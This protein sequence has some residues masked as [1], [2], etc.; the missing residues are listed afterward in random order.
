MKKWWL[1][2][3]AAWLIWP[4]SLQ[5]ADLVAHPNGAARSFSQLKAPV[6]IIN[7]WATWCGPCRKEMPE[8]S[9]WYKKQ[10][11]GTVDLVG[12][13]LDRADNINRFLVKTPVSYPIWRYEGNDSRGFMQSLGNR[14]GV[15]PYTVVEASG[16]SSKETITGEVNAAKLSAA[17]AKVKKSCKR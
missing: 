17:V 4:L 7:I 3:L 8:M 1:A 12:V 15:V 13:A 11:K 14:V 16:C 9:A 5:A 2:A 6:R 10:K